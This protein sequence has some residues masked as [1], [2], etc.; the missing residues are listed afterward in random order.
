MEL[1]EQNMTFIILHEK[2]QKSEEK[3]LV[4]YQVFIVEASIRV[5]L[6]KE[7]KMAEGV[8]NSKSLLHH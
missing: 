3:H 4:L 6:Q 1:K 8:H 5:S 7:R 2:I